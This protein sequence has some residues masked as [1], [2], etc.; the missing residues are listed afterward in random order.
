MAMVGKR[1]AASANWPKTTGNFGN[2]LR[3][4]AP[5]RRLH[6]VN[7]SFER[8]HDGR[9]II[10]KSERVPIAPAGDARAKTES[11]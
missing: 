5:Q 1:I 3:R 7:V 8:R 9:I 6:G 4:L 11:S 2:G 10:L